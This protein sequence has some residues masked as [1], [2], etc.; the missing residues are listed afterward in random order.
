[1]GTKFEIWSCLAG[2][3][4]QFEAGIE[5]VVQ[6]RCGS[7]LG[8]DGVP[9]DQ[10]IF[11]AD[12]RMYG[13]KPCD[14]Q[15]FPTDTGCRWTNRQKTLKEMRVLSTLG[16]MQFWEAIGTQ[17]FGVNVQDF[18]E[19]FGSNEAPIYQTS[20]IMKEVWIVRYIRSWNSKGMW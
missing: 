2:T 7:N 19:I 17:L 6:T 5:F 9:Y 11:H 14:R 12:A 13:R 3:E 20:K 1:M 18:W 16:N 15:D 4:F 8:R 10:P